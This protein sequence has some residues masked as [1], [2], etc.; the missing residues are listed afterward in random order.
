MFKFLC[1]VGLRHWGEWRLV[2]YGEHLLNEH[3]CKRCGYVVREAALR[4]G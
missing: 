4:K 3:R 2:T 1:S